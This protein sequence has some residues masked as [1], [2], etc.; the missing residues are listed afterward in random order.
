[1][2]HFAEYIPV[3][4]RCVRLSG[5]ITENDEYELKKSTSDFQ[6]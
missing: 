4:K 5:S 3:L 2:I 6:I 1:M